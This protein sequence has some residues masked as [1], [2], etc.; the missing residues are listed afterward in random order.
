[1]ASTSISN[2]NIKLTG[3]NAY[4]LHEKLLKMSKT[5]VIRI[6]GDKITGNGYLIYDDAVANN[7]TFTTENLSLT[8]DNVEIADTVNTTTG[9]KGGNKYENSPVVK[10]AVSG[11]SS[12]IATIGGVG[13]ASLAEAIAAA[14]D[15]DTVTLLADITEDVV[16]NKNITFDLGG[17][18]ITNTGAGKATLTV[19][20]GATATVKNGSIVGGASY[21]NI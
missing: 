15:G 6:S 7:S 17:K 10:E 5:P 11:A 16:I 3:G 13:Y 12:A 14:K 18:T 19:A 4:T 2:N 1:M 9:V 8:F 21:Y 20:S